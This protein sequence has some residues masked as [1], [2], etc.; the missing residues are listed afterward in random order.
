M[1]TAVAT[2]PDLYEVI[3]GEIVELPPISIESVRIAS[4]V[5]TRINMHAYRKRSRKP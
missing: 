5:I 3:N 4:E 1:T 2:L